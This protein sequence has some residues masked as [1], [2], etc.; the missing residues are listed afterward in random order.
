MTEDDE[1]VI[2][3]LSLRLPESDNV[4]EFWKNLVNGVDMVT[5]DDRRW[6]PGES[7]VFSLRRIFAVL[8][9]E[10]YFSHYRHFAL[11]QIPTYSPQYDA[12]FQ[13]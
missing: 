5:E 12:L 8:I 4:E 1:L 9:L 6:P 13:C 7:N 10:V 2:S 11:V 3:G